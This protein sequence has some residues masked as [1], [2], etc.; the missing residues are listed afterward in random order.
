[1]K[2]I[3]FSIKNGVSYFHYKSSEIISFARRG[4]LYGDVGF[5]LM[6]RKGNLLTYKGFGTIEKPSKHISSISIVHFPPFDGKMP[7]D[8][9]RVKLNEQKQS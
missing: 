2:P 3:R 9:E 6:S 4:F 5:I 7:T 8:E 1:M